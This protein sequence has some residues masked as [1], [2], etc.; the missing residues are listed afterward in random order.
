M[1]YHRCA[2]YACENYI[3]R[4]H[5][6]HLDIAKCAGKS[7]SDQETISKISLNEFQVYF[8]EQYCTYLRNDLLVRMASFRKGNLDGFRNLTTRFPTISL[9]KVNFKRVI[10]VID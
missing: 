8:C 9:V 4:F 2:F 1:Q 6:S 7:Y 3:L 10:S 5:E